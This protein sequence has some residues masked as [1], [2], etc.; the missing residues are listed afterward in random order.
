MLRRRALA[1]V[2]VAAGAMWFVASPGANANGV[3]QMVKLTY[4]EGVS[5]T[6]SK[7]AE[8]V[9]EFSFAEAYA[10]VTA[11]GLDELR[12]GES[13]QGWLIKSGS[14]QSLNLGVLAVEDTGLAQLDAELPV[15]EDYDY[16][17]FVIT[18][19]EGLIETPRP[20]IHQTIGGFFSIIEP[21]VTPTPASNDTQPNNPS[22]ES[23]PS[24][25]PATGTLD[26]SNDVIRSA[27]LLVL[28]LTG[29]SFSIRWGR[30][31]RRGEEP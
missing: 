10:K 7:D 20:S 9:L 21:V 18:L 29:I 12:D 3:P 31:Y 8:G 16:D 22:A 19:E 2:A 6:G 11:E 17:F 26:T 23:K 25:L 5:N 1:L 27:L 24:T 14:E 13:Y 28:M 4:I 30:R 15:I